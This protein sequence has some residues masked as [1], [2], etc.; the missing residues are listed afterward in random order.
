MTLLKNFLNSGHL[1]NNE[2]NLKGFQFSLLNSLL[3]T[4]I[5]FASASYVA[6]IIGLFTLTQ[7]YENILILY[8]VTNIYQLILL[9]RDEKNYLIVAHTTLLISLLLFYF[10]LI[11]PKDEFRLIWFFLVLFAEFILL[12]KRVGLVWMVLILSSIFTLNYYYPLGFSSLALFTFFNSFLIFSVFLYFFIDKIEKDAKELMRLKASVETKM[13]KALDAHAEKELLLKEVHHRVKNNLHII[14]S[15]IQLQEH[16]VNDEQSKIL[17]RELE[18]R[19]NT[20]AKS[21]EMLTVT[22]TF[23]SINMPQYISQLMQ[24]IEESFEG[25]SMKVEI[26]SHVNAVLPL[27]EAVYVG[28]IVNELLTNA[29]KYAFPSTVDSMVGSIDISLIQDNNTYTLK[30]KDNGIGFDKEVQQTS[31]GTQLMK[32]LIEDQLQGTLSVNV[33]EGTECIVQ[34]TV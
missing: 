25:A 23:E 17:F 26:R 18:N 10:A 22:D 19:I 31:V 16:Q 6:S 21:Y 12:G 7:E 28:L 8:I 27:K 15:M 29:Y 5:S 4:T 1:L 14:L 24:D 2:E 11:T 20:I 32:A 30:I 34:F 3:L 9:R 33:K 13:Y